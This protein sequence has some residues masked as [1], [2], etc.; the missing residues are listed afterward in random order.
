MYK[1]QII[2]KTFIDRHRNLN[3]LNKNDILEDDKEII[4]HNNNAIIEAIDFIDNKKNDNLTNKQIKLFNK[5]IANFDKYR[6]NKKYKLLFM[7]LDMGQFKLL[8]KNQNN[9]TIKEIDGSNYDII[10][11]YFQK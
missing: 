6:L 1:H 10:L 5:F 3:N 4:W 7:Y 8:T 11:N 9:I 2:F